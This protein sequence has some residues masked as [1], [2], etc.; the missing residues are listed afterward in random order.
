M[1]EAMIDQAARAE[2]RASADCWME[3]RTFFIAVP[4]ANSV[5][6]PRATWTADYRVTKAMAPPADTFLLRRPAFGFQGNYDR[7]LISRC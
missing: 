7:T 3:R 6:V 1:P 4:T 5:S 2:K